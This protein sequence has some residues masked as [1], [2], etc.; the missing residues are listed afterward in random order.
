MFTNAFMMHIQI[1]R[2]L[3]IYIKNLKMYVFKIKVKHPNRDS[4]I[5]YHIY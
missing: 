4:L 3:I 2:V 1:F 5:L